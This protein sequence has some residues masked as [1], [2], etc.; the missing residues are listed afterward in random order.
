MSFSLPGGKAPG[1]RRAA[2]AAAL[3]GLALAGCSP[4]PTGMSFAARVSG[5]APR[6]SGQVMSFA[7]GGVLLAAPE[8]FCFDRRSSTADDS[9]GFALITHCSRLDRNRWF[10]SRN[11]AV[12][13][14]SIGPAQQDAAAP[15]A[16]DIVAMFP[17]A[18]LLETRD[19]QLLP[20]VRLEFPEA[21]AEGASPVHWRGAFVLDRHLVALA[22]YA[23][24]GSRA[25]GGQG[26]AL[27]N[28]VTHRSLEASTLPDLEEAG[29]VLPK[30][31]RQ[32]LRPLA[33]PAAAAAGAPET[34]ATPALRKKRGL[35]QR[36]AGLFQ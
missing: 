34:G 10:G 8:T 7:G 1:L 25:L 12:L 16:A 20:L 24:E 22:L 17:G 36:I 21:V 31:P 4:A 15:Q 29:A 32:S 3:A 11:A 13:T 6:L 14:A 27:L 19:D 5:P 26:A 35:S 2:A 30:G 33:R 28:E 9:G 23:P 18:T